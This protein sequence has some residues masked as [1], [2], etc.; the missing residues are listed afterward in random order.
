MDK[1]AVAPAVGAKEKIEKQARQLAYDS[2][3][4]VKQAMKAKAGGRVDPA[5]MRKAYISQLAKSPAAPAIKARAK[6]MLMGEGYID[7]NNLVK[8][9]TTSILKKIFV[10]K[11]SNIPIH[12][13]YILNR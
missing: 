8:E 11:I 13:R 2:R 10:E 6:Q 9:S 1:P 7:V 12:K 5:A 3:Y 4:K